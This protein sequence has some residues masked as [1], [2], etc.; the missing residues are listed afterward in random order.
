MQ[1]T[2]FIENID[3]IFETLRELVSFCARV[4]C[5]CTLLAGL[6]AYLLLASFGGGRSVR[7]TILDGESRSPS[8]P[9]NELAAFKN[10]ISSRS[11]NL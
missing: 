4:S 6:Y 10:M 9:C 3:H 1:L 5:Y 8:D 2:R 11:K 7:V